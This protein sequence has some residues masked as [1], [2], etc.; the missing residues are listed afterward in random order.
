M[1]REEGFLFTGNHTRSTSTQNILKPCPRPSPELTMCQNT[2]RCA[3]EPLGE[4]VDLDRLVELGLPTF[5]QTRQ[6]EHQHPGGQHRVTRNRSPL[7]A[8]FVA[9][10]QR[11]YGRGVAKS[12]ER[13]RG[14]SHPVHWPDRKEEAAG[15]GELATLLQHVRYVAI[16]CERTQARTE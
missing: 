14:R 8:E 6:R 7:E 15:H 2:W 13:W 11:Q 1:G 12:S 9:A 4:E 5:D 3:G 10:S 16:V